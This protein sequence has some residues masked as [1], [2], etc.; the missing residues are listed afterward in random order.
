MAAP[1]IA[2]FI[3]LGNMGSYM[4]RNMINKGY[5]LVVHD[6]VPAV[7]SKFVSEGSGATAASSP[8]QLAEMCGEKGA[9]AI[10]SMVPEGSHMREVYLGSDGVLKGGPSKSTLLLDSSTIDIDSAQQVEKEA[11]KL[12][13]TFMDCPVSGAV[14]AAKAATLTFMIG[15]PK[16]EE[17]KTVLEPMGQRFFH[18]GP[19][20][21]GLTAKI[22]NNMMLAISMI[23]TSE[24][25]NLGARMGLDPKLLTDILCVSSGRCWSVDTYNPVPG[26]KE[27]VPASN[28]YKD[29]FGTA[30][31]TKDLGLAQT[32]ATK[33]KSA[34]PLG[35]ISHQI[36]RTM[37]AQGYGSKDFS[38]IYKILSAN[39]SQ[40]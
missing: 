36:Y 21:S 23:G 10:I 4:A 34:T 38:V 6:A 27:S 20:G 1:K 26:I 40:K 18:C 13:Y 14:P 9:A 15:G 35:S 11:S 12:G 33:S 29:G 3:G 2:G 31:I 24:T 37:C 39:D 25:L 22:C 19:V 32:E 8:A 16:F 5:Q 28:D 7:T 30:L 17:A